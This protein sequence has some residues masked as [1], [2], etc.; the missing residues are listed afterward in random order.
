M[1][2]QYNKRMLPSDGADA[3]QTVL[4]IEMGAKKDMLDGDKASSI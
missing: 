1:Q 3:S 4:L 2:A